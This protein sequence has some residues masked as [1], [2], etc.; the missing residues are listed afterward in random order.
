MQLFNDLKSFVGFDQE[1]ATR[2]RELE[3]LVA[4]HYDRVVDRFFEALQDNQHTRGIFEDSDQIERA[5]EAVYAWLE[6]VFRGQYGESYREHREQIGERHVEVGLKP[7]Y[8]F[9]AMNLLRTELTR[10]VVEDDPD[11]IALADALGSIDRILDLELTLMLNGY[12]N[13]LIAEKA[14]AGLELATRL[15]HEI[16]NPLNAIGLNLTLLER[17]LASVLDKDGKYNSTL[18]AIRTELQR[19]EGLTKEIKEYAQPISPSP[20]W[21]RLPDLLDEIEA[22]Y[23]STLE[24]NSIELETDLGEEAHQIFCDPEH[25]KRALVNLVE[26]AIEA[27]DHE[28][29]IEVEVRAQNGRTVMEVTDTGDGITPTATDRVFDLFYTTKASGTGIGLPIVKK[30][31]D[32]HQGTVEFLSHSNRDGT[33]IRLTLPRPERSN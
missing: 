22:A 14:E 30:I 26:N 17:K 28:G 19:V 1:D 11:E 16:R 12:W 8:M 18:Q 21:H 32:A 31:V 33:S 23:A 29:T 27:I 20:S 6:D 15:A 9:V 4:P 2:L 3:P 24:A 25:F 5:Q 10:I 7:Q 13:A